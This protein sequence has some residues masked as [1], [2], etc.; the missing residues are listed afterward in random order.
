MLYMTYHYIRRDITSPSMSA[1]LD[2]FH[3]ILDEIAHSSSV[4]E[5]QRHCKAISERAF[6]VAETTQ[7]S[8]MSG[9]VISSYDTMW[10]VDYSFALGNEMEYVDYACFPE[11]RYI[12]MIYRI[13]I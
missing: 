11:A 4:E 2:S 12:S 6:K 5:V 9:D 10:L 8:I 3:F 7:D 1:I 13:G